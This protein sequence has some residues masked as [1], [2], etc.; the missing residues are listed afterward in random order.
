[1]RAPLMQTT[2]DFF[3][4]FPSELHVSNH[5]HNA[6]IQTMFRYQ[7]G[8]MVIKSFTYGSRS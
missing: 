3:S 6:T 8:K 2:T 7:W 5:F 4:Q 1:M